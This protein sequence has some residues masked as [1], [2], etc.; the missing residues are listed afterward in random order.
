MSSSS[1]DREAAPAED[2]AHAFALTNL[3]LALDAGKRSA[4]STL[5]LLT[6]ADSGNKDGHPLRGNIKH[7]TGTSEYSPY[8]VWKE[9]K[10]SNDVDHIYSI[11][12]ERDSYGECGGAVG[13][14][15]LPADS[16]LCVRSTSGPFPETAYEVA[17]DQTRMYAKPSSV[18]TS[19]GRTRDIND[20]NPIEGVAEVQDEVDVTVDQPVVSRS[21]AERLKYSFITSPFEIV[22]KKLTKPGPI[23]GTQTKKSNDENK[24]DTLSQSISKLYHNFPHFQTKSINDASRNKPGDVKFQSDAVLDLEKKMSPASLPS[25]PM[26]FRTS[27]SKTFARLSLRIPN[28]NSP[29]MA[30]SK[31]ESKFQFPDSAN[32][33]QVIDSSADTQS[34]KLLPTISQNVT[35]TRLINLS[36]FQIPSRHQIKSNPG[37]TTSPEITINQKSMTLPD[38]KRIQNAMTSLDMTSNQN[39][40]T[41]PVFVCNQ[42]STSQVPS[43][44]NTGAIVTHGAQNV[45]SKV[46]QVNIPDGNAYGGRKSEMI[47]DSRAAVISPD[48]N[49]KVHTDQSTKGQHGNAKSKQ[50]STYGLEKVLSEINKVSKTAKS[51]E[52]SSA[53]ISKSSKPPNLAFDAVDFR[54]KKSAPN[55]PQ[56]FQSPPNRLTSFD[57][58]DKSFS[59]KQFYHESLPYNNLDDQCSSLSGANISSSLQSFA[60]DYTNDTSQIWTSTRT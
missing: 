31:S 48:P 28:G 11:L 20:I 2:V 22:K 18:D 37:S 1:R 27:A 29:D 4:T 51:K 15:D 43:K 44:L 17:T 34:L 45:S 56:P 36:S 35:E 54:M 7:Q 32:P 12:E 3:G 9:Q 60:S 53:D 58:P 39:S 21:L 38:M 24:H 59:R 42:H 25:S 16:N 47:T 14:N 8:P 23:T 6:N 26:F 40:M 55:Q 57:F 13:Y 41:S 52:A 5:Y 49:I 19:V 46:L 10:D 30:S 50:N 33:A